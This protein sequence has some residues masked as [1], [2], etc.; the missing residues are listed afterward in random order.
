VDNFVLLYVCH[1]QLTAE[2][3]EPSSSAVVD[4]E[5]LH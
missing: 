2:R 5:K 3:K 4:V 1:D